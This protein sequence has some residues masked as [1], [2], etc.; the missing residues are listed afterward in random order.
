MVSGENKAAP[1][2]PTGPAKE[3]PEFVS[4][5]ISTAQ[6][7]AIA[8]ESDRRTARGERSGISEILRECI[9]GHLTTLGWTFE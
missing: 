6:R 9:E 7:Q 2:R 1:R 5:N 8:G 4:G 3:Y